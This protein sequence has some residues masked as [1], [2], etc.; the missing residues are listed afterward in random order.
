[1]IMGSL[2]VLE[3]LV[4]VDPKKKTTVLSIIEFIK[5]W[6]DLGSLH[7]LSSLENQM[8]YMYH[9]IKLQDTFSTMLLNPSHIFQFAY[10][11]TTK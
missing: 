3:N 1:M 11:F 5:A 8:R 9:S 7:G 4:R 6:H 10:T 2:K